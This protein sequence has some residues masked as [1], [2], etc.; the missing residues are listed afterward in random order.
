MTGQVAEAVK[1]ERSAA[2]SEA[3]RSM[4]LS[5]AARRIG[6]AAE[7]LFEER[8]A[9]GRYWLGHTKEMLDAFFESPED[10][11][12]RIL[13][14]CIKDVLPDGTLLAEKMD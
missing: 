2:L 7:I 3:E 13:T 6:S 11:T 9:S 8:D 14:L 4:R 5:Y 12:G 10:L 1:K